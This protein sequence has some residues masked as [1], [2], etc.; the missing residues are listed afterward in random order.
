[1][2][3]LERRT[4]TDRE[5]A[6]MRYHFYDGMSYTQIAGIYQ[7]TKQRIDQIILKHIRI[8]KDRLKRYDD[9]DYVF[10]GLLNL[11]EIRYIENAKVIKYS[12][13]RKALETKNY[14]GY[15]KIKGIGHKKETMLLRIMDK[16]E[17]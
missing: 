5:K 9:V 1:M 6:I 8:F 7:L 15:N 4:M 13:L 11:D 10:R 16:I 3:N 14:Y 12:D 2:N 17:K